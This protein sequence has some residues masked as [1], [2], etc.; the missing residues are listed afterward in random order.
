MTPNEKEVLIEMLM[1]VSGL[2]ED[3]EMLSDETPFNLPINYRYPLKDELYGVALMLKD[4]E[5]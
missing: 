2:L 5:L 4:S 1:E 3:F